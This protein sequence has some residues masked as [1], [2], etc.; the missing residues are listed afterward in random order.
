MDVSRPRPGLLLPMSCWLLNEYRVIHRSDYHQVLVDAATAA[1]A[2]IRLGAEVEDLDF[3]SASIWLS[4]GTIIHGDVIIGADGRLHTRLMT[5]KI[6]S[7]VTSVRSV[8]SFARQTPRSPV[9]AGR[10]R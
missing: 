3:N 2:E 8:V 7:P 6:C 5:V 10:D 9:T 4:D 1:G